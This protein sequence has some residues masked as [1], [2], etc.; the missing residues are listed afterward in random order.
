MG[1][2]GD[3]WKRRFRATA[4]LLG[5]GFAN[6]ACADAITF[7]GIITQ[8]TSDGTGPAMNNPSLNNI[9]DGDSFAVTLAFTG[10]ITGP[11]TSGLPGATLVFVDSTASVSET[12]LGGSKSVSVASDGGSYD[13][14]VFGC[15]STGSDGCLGGNYLSANFQIPMSALNSA[16]VTAQLVPN[17]YPALDL[18]ED[19]G[20]TDIQGSINSYSYTQAPEPSSA[21]LLFFGAAALAFAKQAA[22]RRET[23]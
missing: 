14:S 18:L 23:F 21:A 11:G 7:S 4:F 19:D 13:L 22:A 6:L 2:S 9:A 5:I 15:L 16:N 3:T 10:S 17:L 8:S 12:A 1:I 20:T